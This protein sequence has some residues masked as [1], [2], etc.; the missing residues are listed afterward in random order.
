MGRRGGARPG[1]G[2]DRLRER[3][4]HEAARIMHEQG[5]RDYGLAKRKAAERLGVPDGCGLPRNAEIEAALA[6]YRRLFDGEHA[7][8]LR[9]LRR[10]ALEAM[11]L[12]SAF[13]PRLVGSVLSG[14]AGAHS[15]INLH[16]FADTPEAVALFLAAR[17]IPYE[18][19]ERRLRPSAGHDPRGYPAFR[20]VT[21]E[22]T[23]ELTVFPVDGLR[24]AP[25]SPVDGRPMRRAALAA[26][27]ALLAQ[28]DGAEGLPPRA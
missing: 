12:L 8:R 22:F 16:L 13:E 24:Q 7:A 11:R 14:T 17:H 25:C 19:C 4:A 5:I 28:P 3:I 10:T 18:E 15:D 21:G 27:E 1:R 9:R 26:V 20:F 23:V 2:A 6:A